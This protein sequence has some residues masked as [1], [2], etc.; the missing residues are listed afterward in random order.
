MRESR[1]LLSTSNFHQIAS[2]MKSA[3]RRFISWLARHD[4]GYRLMDIL[5]LRAARIAEE[6]RK[7]TVDRRRTHEI[8]RERFADLT[9]RH[10]PFCGLKYAAPESA[11]SALLPKL[12][13]SYESELHSVFEALCRADCRTVIDIGCAE[14]YYAVGLARLMPNARVVAFDIDARARAL[15]RSM[16]EANGVS[17]RVMIEGACGPDELCV[18]AAGASGL[19]V[20]DCEGYERDL[21]TPAAV[22]VLA[23]FQVV[24]EVH[25]FTAT[26]LSS[27]LAARFA[28]SHE[29]AVIP[30][31]D[32][33]VKVQTYRYPEIDAL[34]AATRRFILAERRPG[35][36]D[37]LVMRPRRRLS[38]TSEPR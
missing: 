15:C 9:V 11:C 20:C 30:C 19:L 36:M 17:D 37:W 22:E 21:F 5:F 25:D 34:D 16:A 33:E 3:L 7:E 18:L 12:L 35:G 32:D 14:G 26:G 6:E 24:I 1:R 31:K 4:A 38:T 29:V 13:G 28:R 2:P 27:E 8:I 23:D 10:G